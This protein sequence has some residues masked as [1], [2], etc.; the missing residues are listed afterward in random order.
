ME[1]QDIFDLRRALCSET[2]QEWIQT[3]FRHEVEEVLIWWHHP[4]PPPG[5]SEPRAR[6]QTHAPISMSRNLNIRNQDPPKQVNEIC[7]T[8]RMCRSMEYSYLDRSSNLGLDSSDPRIWTMEVYESHPRSMGQLFS[9]PTTGRIVRSK[10]PDKYLWQPPSLHAQVLCMPFCKQPFLGHH[11]GLV[12]H[13]QWVRLSL[14]EKIWGR[15]PNRPQKQVHR[16]L[17]KELWVL[18]PYH[19]W[20]EYTGSDVLALGEHVT[21]AT[22]TPC[23]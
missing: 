16:K 5:F 20:E 19:M 22:H 18:C 12:V 4:A 11:V 1:A 8:H 3:H 2:G 7:L 9:V 10:G 17:C 6:V 23:L 14:G 15:G 13:P 21:L